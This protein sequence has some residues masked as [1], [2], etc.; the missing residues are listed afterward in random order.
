MRASSKPRLWLSRPFAYTTSASVPL[1]DWN[2]K[3]IAHVAFKRSSNLLKLYRHISFYMFLT[4][5][6]SILIAWL[7]IGV[8]TRIWMTIPLRQIRKILETENGNDRLIGDLKNSPGEFRQIGTLF[9]DFVDQKKELQR[10]KEK[11]E[12]AAS[13]DTSAT[14]MQASQGAM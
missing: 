3:E 2:R 8:T 4:M 10:A 12:K 5:L 6:I 13:G 9:S 14:S 11:A 1:Y 7:M